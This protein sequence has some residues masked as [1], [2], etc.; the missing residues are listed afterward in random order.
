MAIAGDEGED[1]PN[2]NINFLKENIVDST[3]LQ[4]QGLMLISAE[5][6]RKLIESKSDWLAD[7]PSTL[8]FSSGTKQG[9]RRFI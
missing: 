8:I 6:L 4:Q 9:L 3:F 5:S 1:T 7:I 2:D